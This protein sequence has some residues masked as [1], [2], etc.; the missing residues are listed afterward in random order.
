MNYF[1]A[2]AN[3]LTQVMIWVM[4]I[5]LLMTILVQTASA[6]S[7]RVYSVTRVEPW[8][9]LN[10]RVAPGASQDVVGNIP[11]NGEGVIY[12]GDR[13]SLDN[14]E[15]YRVA[16]GALQGW[17]NAHYLSPIETE[18][19]NRTAPVESVDQLPRQAYRSGI[20]NNLPY[21]YPNT[22]PNPRKAP[23]ESVFDKPAQSKRDQASV[24]LEC[25]GAEPFWNVD[26]SKQSLKI[27]VK[28][29]RRTLP[30]LEAST[31][32]S[33]SLEKLTTLTA[34]Q[35]RDE[36]KL[37]LVRTEQCQDGITSI[38]YPFSVKA[39]VN[40]HTSFNGCCKVFHSSR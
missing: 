23:P 33:G 37:L 7:G 18:A 31:L 35:G 6:F 25:G 11:A 1:N 27:N 4:S 16:W 40:G 22:Y 20:W 13:K 30:L 39:V 12:L 28:N 29:E 8:D 38:Q 2:N 32:Q 34:R 19:A 10:V 36:V 5:F 14:D 3:K 17:V 24:V 21:E 26:V 9:T 15:W